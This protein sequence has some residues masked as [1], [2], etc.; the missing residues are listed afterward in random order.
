MA[1]EV[2]KLS[3]IFV[4]FLMIMLVIYIFKNIIYYFRLSRVYKALNV[5]NN[6]ELFLKKIDKFIFRTKDKKNLMLLKISKGAALSQLGRFEDSYIITKSVDTNLLKGT[7]KIV[8]YNNL[9]YDLLL[10]GRYGEAKEFYIVNSDVFSEKITNVQLLTAIKE[11]L[12]TYEFYLGDIAISEQ[13]FN[14][15]LNNKHL[16]KHQKSSIYY[17]LG[18]IYIR[19]NNINKAIEYLNMIDS[20]EK[21]LYLKEQ[22]ALLI[23]KYQ[24]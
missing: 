10:M 2:L 3:A 4:Y 18:L 1:E 13:K 14:E 17:H 20:N 21:C 15:L 8:Y 7:E 19:Y 6:P 9:L 12:A 24:N 23:R 11:T 5:Q 22:A 16:S